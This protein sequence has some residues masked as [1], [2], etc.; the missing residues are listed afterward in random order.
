MKKIELKYDI[1]KYTNSSVKL[2]N[3]KLID[4]SNKL[5]SCKEKL[6][7][8][9]K[10]F[11]LDK[12]KYFFN[13]YSSCLTKI[14]NFVALIDIYNSSYKASKKYGYCK[15]TIENKD[16][17]YFDAKEMRHPIIERL[18]FSPEYV[19]NNISLGNEELKGILLY[20]VNGSG[21]SS[22]SKAIGLN[23][24]LAQI[25]MY[26][27]CKE[28]IFS[29]YNK[30]FTRISCDDNIFKGQSSFVVEMSELR[31]IL[32]YS[33]SKSIVLGDEVCKGTEEVSALAIVHASIKTFIKKKVNFMLATHFHKLYDI[34]NEEKLDNVK[35][36]H[37]SVEF[38]NDVVIYGRKI[39]D[40]PGD[41]IYGLEIAKYIINDDDFILIANNSRDR[42]M[43]RKKELLDSKLS[44]YNKNLFMDKCAICNKGNEVVLHTHHIKEQNEFN[45]DKLL[46]HIKKII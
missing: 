32:K 41:T 42:I 20:G 5:V 34:C 46:G 24:V 22:L 4:N 30:I 29:P 1:K 23:I 36:K 28:F 35:F 37:L 38:D 19:T 40:G 9:V 2:I 16:I 3:Q 31:S 17:S 8:V 27:P 18:P 15:P 25:G 21:K 11:Y 10:K 6:K 7:S 44:N 33:D 26:V 43:N 39:K 14:N 45:E 13:K 12:I